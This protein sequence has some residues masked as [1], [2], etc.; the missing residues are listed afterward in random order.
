MA[1]PHDHLDDIV[2]FSR[3]RSAQRH[4]ACVAV[5]AGCVLMLSAFGAAV[6]A[7]RVLVRLVPV[8]AGP[9]TWQATLLVVFLVAAAIGAAVADAAG[10][11]DRDEESPR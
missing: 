6:L 3:P 7:V 8:L 4:R 10:P 5:A 9:R 11:V 2:R 1:G